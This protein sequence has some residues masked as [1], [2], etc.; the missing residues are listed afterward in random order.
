MDIL[1]PVAVTVSIVTVVAQASDDGGLNLTDLL[2]YGVLGI[3]L[4]LVM[5]GDL[6]LKREVE[7]RDKRLQKQDS[8][9]EDYRAMYEREVIPMLSNA[10]E[11]M[12]ELREGRGDG[13]GR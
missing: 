7:E 12:R 5:R 2:Q 11:L 1:A 8:V 13:D 3:L 9:I 4:I 10:V 6:R